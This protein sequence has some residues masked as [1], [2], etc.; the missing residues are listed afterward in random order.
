MHDDIAQIQ[1]SI[2]YHQPVVPAEQKDVEKPKHA[3][4]CDMVQ[5][6]YS[7]ILN[8][9]NLEVVLSVCSYNCRLSGFCDGLHLQFATVGNIFGLA[10]SC[11]DELP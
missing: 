8:A 5:V 7:Q 11:S 4:K 9:K 1:L 10:L 3:L 2:C 6:K